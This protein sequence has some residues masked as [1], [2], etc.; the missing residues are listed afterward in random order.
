MRSTLFVL[1]VMA[2][3]LAAGASS[4]WIQTEGGR[5]RLVVLPE[6]ADG[7]IP[8]LLDVHLEAGWKTYWRDPGQSGI[9]PSVSIPNASGLVL[10]SMRFPVP[11]HFDDGYSRYTGYDQSVAFPLTLRRK[12]SAAGSDEVTAS[13]FLGMCKDICI[14]VQAELTVDLKA[15]AMAGSGDA[16]VL[17]A[18]KAGL[19]E[20][21]S[22]DFNIREA[23]WDAD[24]KS[25]SVTFIA[26]PQ[27]SDKPP[28][29]FVSGPEGFQFG[30]GAIPQRVGDAYRVDVPL[31]HK[32]KS[33]GLTGAP[34][35]F[36]AESGDR[37]ME[38]AL[39]ID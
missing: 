19:P 25:L 21:P 23:R 14:P 30:A 27:Q 24:G 35:L 15:A 36:T 31:L 8:A 29:V 5:V 13:I 11:K 16:T 12:G 3:T 38:T 2:P 39:A 37:S 9:P 20:P 7:E 32:P 22:P 6:Q 26:P 34:I 28:Q 4:D 33:S 18:A 17:A 1:A 10:E